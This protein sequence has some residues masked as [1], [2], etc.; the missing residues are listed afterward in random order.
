M[1]RRVTPLGG[2]SIGTGLAVESIF[3][4][5]QLFDKNRVIP[6]KVVINN[7]THHVYNILLLFRNLK[8]SFSKEDLQKVKDKDLLSLL[9]DEIY[10][11]VSLYD[12]VHI[13]C[14]PVIFKP[15][16]EKIYKGLNQGKTTGVTKTYIANEL[17][18][19]QL[20]HFKLG[21]VATVMNT[22][23]LPYIKGN[24]LITTGMPVDLLS[25]NKLDLLESHTGKLKTRREFH[26]KFNQLGKK[27]SSHIPFIGETVYF[28][29]DGNI[30]L[31]HS[32]A[33]KK[34]FYNLSIDK[35]WTNRTTADKI[36]SDIRTIP[37]L[38]EVLK[39]YKSLF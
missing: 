19:H 17:M 38:K 18:M 5:E 8:N 27:S 37:E 6:N 20:K 29:G 11:L 7:Y 1:D 30:V 4:T 28:M 32:R 12:D 25:K 35:S 31:P 9:Q 15:N 39:N 22:Y 3:E 16:Y 33:T 2:L 36:V 14:V 34:K 10:S 24:V 13:K 23:Q 26:T 21:D